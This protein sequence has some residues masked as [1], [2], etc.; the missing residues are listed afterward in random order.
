M[1]FN[2]KWIY[3]MCYIAIA[4]HMLKK[5]Y[6]KS[7][8]RK[9]FETIKKSNR[10]I[11]SGYFPLTDHVLASYIPSFED[12]GCWDTF[13]IIIMFRGTDINACVAVDN[14]VGALQYIKEQIRC[15][16]PYNDAYNIGI[17]PIS[18]EIPISRTD[19]LFKQCGLNRV[20]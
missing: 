14:N 17:L 6:E 7:T 19:V 9:L 18:T 5:I 16:Y 12:A 10:T 13:G 2:M 8:G 1:Q 20:E 11:D 15:H 4:L 3:R